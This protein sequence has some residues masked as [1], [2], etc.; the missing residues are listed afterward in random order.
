MMCWGSNNDGELGDGTMTDRLIP[1]D[2]LGLTSGVARISGNGWHTCAALTN[3]ELQC[4]G[5]NGA[6]QL[7]DGTIVNNA[8]PAVVAGLGGSV[9]SLQTG[10]EHT[11]VLL[12][13]GQV[14]CWGGNGFGQLGLGDNPWRLTPVTVKMYLMMLPVVTR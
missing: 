5:Y 10:E 1:T 11:C 3:G 2:V 13:N 6:G 12:T 4:W 9:G 8:T 7:G 14:K